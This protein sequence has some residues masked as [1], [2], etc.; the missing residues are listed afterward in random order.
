[1][2]TRIVKIKLLS[3]CFCGGADQCAPELRA[4]SIRGHLRRWHTRLCSEK[5]MLAVWG[6]SGG[7]GSA[8]RIQLRVESLEFQEKDRPLLPHKIHGCGS[9]RALSGGTFNVHLASRDHAALDKAGKVLLLWSLLGSLGTRAN[10]AAGSVWPVEE[11]P[12]NLDDFSNKLKDIG[13]SKG[14]I[15]ISA[16]TGSAEELRKVASDTLAI[17]GLFGSANPRR[18]SPLKIKIIEFSDGLHLLL[19]AEQPGI[20]DTALEELGKKNKRLAGGNWQKV[21]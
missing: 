2:E 4:P 7:N 19:F 17:P 8:S 21:F 13:F 11:A 14:G 9:R 12:R 16:K 18:E 3:P 1:M 10:R 20:I 6:T 15:R 5:D